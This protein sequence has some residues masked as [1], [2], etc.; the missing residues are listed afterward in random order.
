M[1]NFNKKIISSDQNSKV[2]DNEGNVI[3]VSMFQYD[4]NKKLLSSIG[5]IKIIDKNKNKYFFKELHV[6]TQ[7]KEMIG[8]E[9]SAMLDNENFGV[10]IENDPRFV[11][12]DIFITEDKA[13]LSKGVFTVCKLREDKCPPWSL[14][15][16]KIIHDKTKKTIFYEHAILKVYDFPIFYFP[17]FFHPDPS[18]TR[19]SGFLA[20]FFS[21]SST[22]GTGFGLP[23]FWAIGHDKDFTFT[24]KMYG[25]E[26]ALF[27][28]EYRQAFK[29]GFLTLDTSYTEGYKETTTKK[30]D[31]SRSH[32]FV[33][34]NFNF[35]HDNSYE[36]S[37]Y[38]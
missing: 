37:L 2:V 14:R 38:K 15:A 22:S 18:V 17:R 30:T 3:N 26:N 33:D 11:A 16:K 4:L 9:V 21:N 27:L 25:N 20:P 5:N 10:S 34:S 24:P 28:N 19:K 35:S 12:N 36:S 1:Y 13:T 29:N 7:K 32:V 8:S 31:G 6:D 23:Y